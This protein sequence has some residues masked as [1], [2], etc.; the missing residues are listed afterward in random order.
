MMTRAA[1]AYI[2]LI[3]SS[4]ATILLLAV[5]SWS[6]A[7]L[8]LFLVFLGF[9]AVSSTLKLHIP[10]IEGTMSPNFV[11]LLLAMAFCSY[12]QVMAI[13]FVAALFQS[14]WAA[15]APRLVQVTFS[16]AAI[17]VSASIAFQ[18]SQFLFGPGPRNSPVAFVVFAGSLYLAFNTA[19]VSAVI[20]LVE[21]KPLAQVAR[22]CFECVFPYFATGILFAGL[23]S[24]AFNRSTAWASAIALFPVVVLGYLYS[25]NHSPKVAPV[26][27]ESAYIAD[28]ELVGLGA[29]RRR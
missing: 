3:L 2:A 24:G 7:N 13:T 9:A 17:L 4:G 19:L 29:H 28:E 25:V 16:A 1:K 5:G 26:P 6:S 18:S 10:G 14:L 8:L 20:G 11:F 27:I 22:T 21:G 15:R 23:V 12:S